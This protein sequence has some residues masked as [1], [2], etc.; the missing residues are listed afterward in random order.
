MIASGASAQ[1]ISACVRANGTIKIVSDPADCSDRETPLS[2]NEQ[3]PYAPRFEDCGDGTVADH[4]TGLQWEKKTGTWSSPGVYCDTVPCPDP[5]DVNNKYRWSSTGTEP[6]GSAFT[7]FLA[8][9]NAKF[10]PRNPTG[11]FT[12]RCDWRLPE[13]SELQ[14]ILIGQDAAPGQ[15][16]TCPTAPCIDPDFA[17]VG[18]PTAPL[19]YWSASTYAP[20]PR[21]A[22]RAYFLG[23]GV[24]LPHGYKTFDV[25]ARAVRAGS[26]N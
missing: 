10:R 26:C 20:L 14:T 11:C 9:L 18:G 1:I 13:I 7:D 3:D 2:W 25:L 12:G 23:L 8:R 15:A 6:D 17:A 5:H 24:V 19:Y 22:W 21:Q 16:T 4:R